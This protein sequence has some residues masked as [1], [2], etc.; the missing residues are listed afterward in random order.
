MLNVAMIRGSIDKPAVIS[1]LHACKESLVSCEQYVQKV[2]DGIN[3]IAKTITASGIPRDNGGRGLNP[4][5]Q[6]PSLDLE[7]GNFLGQVNR[8]IKLVCELPLQFLPL[9]RKDS[10]FEHLARRLRGEYSAG[11]ALIDFVEANAAGV[12][13]LIDLRNFHEHP[14]KTKTIIRNFHVLPEGSVGPP[15]WHLQG[16]KS[17]EPRAI[18]WEMPAVVEFMRDMA[19]AMF[20]HLLMCR[21]ETNLPFFVEQVPETEIN[22]SLPIRY[23]LSI[24]FSRL[25][26]AA[27]DDNV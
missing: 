19:E 23:R 15:Y 21:L 5:P 27:A 22:A 3:S 12:R 1:A 17:S 7:C 4:F 16:E 25:Q 6:V 2:T 14:G 8:V 13:Y 9:S 18:A 20:I 26:A 24:D 10:N 11:H